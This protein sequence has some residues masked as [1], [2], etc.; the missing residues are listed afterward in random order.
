MQARQQPLEQLARPCGLKC[1]TATDQAQVRHPRT[2]HRT[3]PERSNHF[4]IAHVDHPDVPVLPGAFACDRKD[5]VRIDRRHGG[6]HDLEM[7]I[8][9]SQAQLRL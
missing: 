3:C 6:V 8:R 9:E 5:G 2:E 1:Q 4:I 7:P